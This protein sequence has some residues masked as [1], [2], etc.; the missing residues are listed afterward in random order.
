MKI[1]SS[2]ANIQEWLTETNCGYCD[3]T[4]E[5]NADDIYFYNDSGDFN[6]KCEVCKNTFIIYEG[7]I[8]IL[9]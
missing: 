6:I 5:I 3:S 4:L 1:I 2:V 9:I 7:D 8:P